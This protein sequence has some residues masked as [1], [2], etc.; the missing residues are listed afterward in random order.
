[1][2]EFQQKIATEILVLVN[3][4]NGHIFAYE[5]DDFLYNTFGENQ[6][7]E[8]TFVISR[9]IEDYN[10]IYRSNAWLCLT[11]NGEI[12]VNLGVAKYIK[13]LH[14]N[15]R[16]DIRMK[17]LEVISKLISIIKDSKTLFIMFITII[18]NLILFL[19][20]YAILLL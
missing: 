14:T 3:N 1:M 9:L 18:V 17:E 16:L 7:E 5:L 6:K 2:N 11:S 20:R 4:H 8:F 19:L 15:K 13:K 12:A 10:L